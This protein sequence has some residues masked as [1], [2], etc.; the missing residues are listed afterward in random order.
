MNYSDINEAWNSPLHKQLQNVQTQHKYMNDGQMETAGIVPPW[1]TNPLPLEEYQDR[2]NVKYPDLSVH[3]SLATPV[4]WLT[5]EKKKKVQCF[6]NDENESNVSNG[7]S[8]CSGKSESD[9]SVNKISAIDSNGKVYRKVNKKKSCDKKQKSKQKQKQ[10]QKSKSK[11]SIM[12]QDFASEGSVETF[13][14]DTTPLDDI[15][16]NSRRSVELN[17]HD[18]EEHIKECLACRQKFMTTTTTTNKNNSV[19]SSFLTDDIKYILLLVL[20]GIFIIFIL[21]L[22]VKMGKNSVT[23][24]KQA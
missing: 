18:I 2:Y 15:N 8:C 23:V 6:K 3:P 9:S 1:S 14:V 19:L 11:Q 16:F 4:E 12:S 5:S 7:S 17:C 10:K 21:D 22:F 24:M 13:S 20:G